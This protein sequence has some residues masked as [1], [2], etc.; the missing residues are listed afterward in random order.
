MALKPIPRNGKIA[1]TCPSSS[2]D[3]ERL[4]DGITYLQNHGYSLVIGESC[5][6]KHAYLSMPD[7]DRAAELMRFFKD[8]SIDAII[9]A[10]GGYGTIRMLPLLDFD[11]IKKAN[12]CLVGYSDVTALAWAIYSKAGIP[13]ISGSMVAADFGDPKATED[14]KQ[15]CLSLLSG[16]NFEISVPIDQ[17]FASRYQNL[18]LTGPLLPGT[19]SVFAKLVGTQYLPNLNNAHILL[20]DIGEPSRKIDGYL[21]QLLH[22]KLL[23]KL[24]SLLIGDFDGREEA[25]EAVYDEAFF[26]DPILKETRIPSYFNWPFGHIPDKR[27]FPVGLS[28]TLS[29]HSNNLVLRANEALF[30]SE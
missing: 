4:N 11:A 20:E 21:Q 30:Q 23:D 6:T 2:V 22:A 28:C 12:K 15:H 1:V 9:C 29:V 24:S 5:T 18:S 14:N 27:S 26:L 16:S 7:E 19:L 10:R 3:A 17:E 8:D 13:S 25:D